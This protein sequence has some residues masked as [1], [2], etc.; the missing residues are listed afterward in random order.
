M[1]RNPAPED[2]SDD[3]LDDAE[4]E[5]E[6]T[7]I[8]EGGGWIYAFTF[9][10]LLTHGFPCPI[11]VGMTAGDVSARVEGQCRASASFSQPQVLGQW[12]VARVGHMEKSIHN[13]LKQ[14]GKW[15]ETAPGAEWFNTSPDEVE[16][17]IGFVSGA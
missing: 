16:S 17:I 4:L 7:V 2:I 11:K 12:R 6:D 14:R 13:V 5:E 15:R 8:L 9:P 1:F 3:E 10:E